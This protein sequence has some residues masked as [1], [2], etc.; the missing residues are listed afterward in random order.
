MVRENRES[1]V[2][3]RDKSYVCLGGRGLNLV[4][5]IACPK[6]RASRLVKS[7][8]TCSTIANHYYLLIVNHVSKSQAILQHHEPFL[9]AIF[10][11]Q[12]FS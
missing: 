1:F 8:V 5:C 9:C 7:C 12:L 11:A 10:H 4:E 6:H 2:R 3:V